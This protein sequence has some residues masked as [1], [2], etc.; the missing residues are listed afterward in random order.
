MK[1]IGY[2]I[3]KKK[4]YFYSFPSTN[5]IKH[6]SIKNKIINTNYMLKID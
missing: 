3:S 6:S 1:H 5:G 4:K 2:N